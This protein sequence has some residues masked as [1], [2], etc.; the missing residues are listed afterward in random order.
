MTHNNLIAAAYSISPTSQKWDGKVESEYYKLLKSIPELKGIEHPFFGELHQFDDNW[1]LNNIDPNWKVIFTGMP[2]VMNNLSKNSQFGIASDDPDGR[3][4]AVDF[5]FKA[6]RAIK[7]MQEHFGKQLVPSIQIHTSP[8]RKAANSSTASLIESL[9]E[10]QAWDWSGTELVI[11]H[12]DAYKEDGSSIKGF[13]TLQEEIDAVI[14]VNAKSDN[15]IG[16]C[17]NWGR[18]AIETRSTQGPIQH[19][20]TLRELNLLRG[21]MFSGVA[22]E[23]ATYGNWQDSHIPP[24]L[25]IEDELYDFSASLLGVNEITE[26][27]NS[28]D[29]DEL[30]FFGAKVSLLP[31]SSSP[32]VCAKFNS[33]VIQLIDCLA[34]D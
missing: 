8:A 17:V 34:K 28:C 15:K 16:F 3:K 30:V 27:L 9:T 25:N 2:G 19:I 26:S 22:A 11:E 33:A 1:F 14:A 18:S 24:Q 31:R 20:S 21:L 4:S 23:D 29:L 32:E 12:C 7:K 10:M 6:S 5:Y 13:L